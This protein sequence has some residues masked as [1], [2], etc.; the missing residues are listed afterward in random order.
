MGPKG[1][2]AQGGPPQG[3]LEFGPDRGPDSNLS[4]QPA[5][6]RALRAPGAK[7]ANLRGVEIYLFPWSVGPALGPLGSDSRA[8]PFL[9]RISRGPQNGL[10]VKHWT[11]PHLGQIEG[12]PSGPRA[13][14]S[15]HSPVERMSI[16]H[17]PG[18]APQGKAPKSE[19]TG[20]LCSEGPGPR[21]R[22][23]N[24][25][26]SASK[27]GLRGPQPN[28]GP[29]TLRSPGPSALRALGPA[30]GCSN[31][32]KVHL[33]PGPRALSQREG[34]QPEGPSK[35]QGRPRL[36]AL[37]PAGGHSDSSELHPRAGP[38]ALSQG[39][40]PELE[41]PFRRPEI[42]SEGPNWGPQGIHG[43]KGC[44]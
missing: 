21:H 31:R 32:G 5:R 37:A 35:S 24:R 43:P 41:G 15:R 42:W 19:I 39:E 13:P 4:A 26:Q 22:T 17:Q 36:R 9:A 6:G 3:P 30:E 1:L 20:A 33:R 27:S 8:Q 2:G 25:A 44:S 23:S 16:R 12:R 38:G 11:V 10:W 18:A 40:G 7:I 28:G 34:A 14:P 29:R